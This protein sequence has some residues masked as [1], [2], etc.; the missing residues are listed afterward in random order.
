[1]VRVAI[2]FALL[3]LLILTASQLSNSKASASTSAKTQ[4]KHYRTLL[5][6]PNR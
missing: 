1:M 4:G 5:S 3:G 6:N 2:A